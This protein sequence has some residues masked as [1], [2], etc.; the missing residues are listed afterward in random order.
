MPDSKRCG[1]HAA[2]VSALTAATS[3]QHPVGQ[4]KGKCKP[5]ENAEKREYVYF[6]YRT[7]SISARTAAR[8]L[9]H[10]LRADKVPNPP[11]L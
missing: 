9:R 6:G 5:Y 8:C 7:H 3:S 10:P 4:N 2:L 11:A 1:Y